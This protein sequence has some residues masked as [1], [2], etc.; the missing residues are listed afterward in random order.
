MRK[1]NPHF[2]KDQLT[3]GEALNRAHFLAMAPF[4]FEA[5]RILRDTGILAQLEDSNPTGCS[6]TDVAGKRGLSMN[7]AQAILEAALGTG[8]A[9]FE[10]ERFHLTM[11]GKYFLHDATVRVNT[12]F[13]RDVCLPGMQHLEESLKTEQPAG[14][15]ALG[16]WRNVFQ[17]LPQL[18]QSVRRSWYAFNDHHSNAAFADA[19]PYVLAGSQRRILDLGGASG[20]FALAAIDRDDAVHVGIADLSLDETTP[21][22]RAAVRAGRISLLPFDVLGGE[23]LPQGYDTI[24]MSQFLPC[25]SE[26]DIVSILAKCA[27]ALPANGTL[28]AMEAFWDRQHYEAA[29]TA[30]QMNSLYFINIATGH[31]RMYPGNELLRI[32]SVAGFELVSGHD[33]MGRG[34]TLLQLRKS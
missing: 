14:L 30:L 6:T 25:F 2:T 23:A 7:S 5:A 18:P 17:A 21:G 13:M 1:R 32:I 9:F 10:N 16:D 19:L 20:R 27:A 29:A 24:W 12:D 3:A 26:Q 22:L 15:K 8:L 34:H 33:G 31:S 11:A 4:A 28:W